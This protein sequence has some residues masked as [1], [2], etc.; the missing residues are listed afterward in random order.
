MIKATAAETRGTGTEGLDA[1]GTFSLS[2]SISCF[3]LTLPFGP[4]ISFQIDLLLLQQNMAP[5]S[6]CSSS[7]APN[8]PR[9]ASDWLCLD[10]VHLLG[11]SQLLGIWSYSF[12]VARMGQAIESVITTRATCSGS[13]GAYSVTRDKLSPLGSDA[14]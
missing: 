6:F 13:G 9:A 11:Q 4:I 14:G 12:P 5:D 3:C 1:S 2:R 10:H 8:G 7:V